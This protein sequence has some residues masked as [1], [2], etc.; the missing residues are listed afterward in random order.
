MTSHLDGSEILRGL[1]DGQVA[2]L[3]RKSMLIA[4]ASNPLG[5]PVTQFA[6]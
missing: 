4:A 2:L 3:F 6:V 5:I 1:T